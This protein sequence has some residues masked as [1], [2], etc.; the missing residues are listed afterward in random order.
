[1]PN[2]AFLDGQLNSDETGYLVTYARLC[3]EAV[4]G[5]KPLDLEQEAKFKDGKVRFPT[6]TSVS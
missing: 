4:N 1:M 6:S 5:T 2:T 3:E